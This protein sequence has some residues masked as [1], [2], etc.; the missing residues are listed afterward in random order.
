MSGLRNGDAVAVTGAAQGI[1][2]AI[3]AFEAPAASPYDDRVMITE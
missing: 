2:R 3:A 1:D